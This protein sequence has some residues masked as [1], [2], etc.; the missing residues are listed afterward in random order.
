MR[1]PSKAAMR[2]HAFWLS[3]LC[4]DL[5]ACRHEWRPA[6]C[7]IFDIDGTLADLSHR[8]HLI[9]RDEPDWDAFHAQCVQDH[10]IF[11]MRDIVTALCL[12]GHRIVFC[13]SRMERNREN[14][15]DWLRTNGFTT[16]LVNGGR[17][18]VMLMR[19]DGDRRDDTIVKQEQLRALRQ[20]GFE[21]TLVFEDRARCAAM[22][23]AEGI[24]CCH[25]ADGDY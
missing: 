21:P 15:V 9:K 2:N 7:V 10:P 20:F 25:V 17:G 8:L 6:K 4:P 19:H 16:Y 18:P 3:T 22:W 1:D 11:P 24:L 23:R 14:T 13:T 5:L 12:S